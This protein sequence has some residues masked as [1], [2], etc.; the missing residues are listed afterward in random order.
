MALWSARFQ[1][2][3]GATRLCANNSIMAGLHPSDEPPA[4]IEQATLDDFL[5][6]DCDIP[7]EDTLLHTI[8]QM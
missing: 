6:P 1:T 3:Y 7:P 2:T 4:E 5:P 8:N